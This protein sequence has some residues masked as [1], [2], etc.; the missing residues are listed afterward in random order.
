MVDWSALGTDPVPGEPDTVRS[1]AQ[2][3]GLVGTDAGEAL[4]RLEAI[5]TRSNSSTW[6]CTSGWPHLRQWRL[7]R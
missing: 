2:R 1:V 7:R 4:R 3:F 6:G 5:G